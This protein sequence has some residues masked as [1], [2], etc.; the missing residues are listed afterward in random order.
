LEVVP[1]DQSPPEVRVF[2]GTPMVL[3]DCCLATMRRYFTNMLLK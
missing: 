3:V 2:S 1:S